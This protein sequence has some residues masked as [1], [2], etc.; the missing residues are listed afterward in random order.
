MSLYQFSQTTRPE[1]FKSTHYVITTTPDGL[2]HW[3]LTGIV[4]VHIKGSGKTWAYHQVRIDLE[5]P[6]IGEN[7]VKIQQWAPFVTLNTIFNEGEA[8]FAGWGVKSFKVLPP[9][10]FEVV[11]QGFLLRNIV[12]ACDIAVRDSDGIIEELGYIV[13]IVGEVVKI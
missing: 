13:H 7:Y 10:G 11:K 12:I 6:G 8:S 5:L 4:D 3:I 1:N 2:W 9:G